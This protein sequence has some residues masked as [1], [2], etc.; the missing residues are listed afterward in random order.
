ER[1]GRGRIL[2]QLKE[3][4]N[5]KYYAEREDDNTGGN[6]VQSSSK[7]KSIPKEEY[8]GFHLSVELLLKN[9]SS[10]LGFHSAPIQIEGEFLTMA[11]D[12]RED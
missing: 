10:E 7:F 12:I 2:L 5:G 4:L 9:E 8:N 6:Y 3:N 11:I 1:Y